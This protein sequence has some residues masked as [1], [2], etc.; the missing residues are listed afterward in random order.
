M[1]AV[2]RRTFE[3]CLFDDL[4]GA[5]TIWVSIEPEGVR[6]IRSW[7]SALAERGLYGCPERNSPARSVSFCCSPRPQASKHAE[8]RYYDVY[9]GALDEKQFASWVKQ[10][11]ALPGWAPTHPP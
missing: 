7:Y 11:A 10:A 8:V 2:E 1:R 3:I 9:E 6:L 5:P 4:A